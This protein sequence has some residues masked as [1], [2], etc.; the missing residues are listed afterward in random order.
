MRAGSRRAPRPRAGPAPAAPAAGAPLAAAALAGRFAA[1]PAAAFTAVHQ[2][3][4]ESAIGWG[5]PGTPPAAGAPEDAADASDA[6]G[7]AES[8]ESAPRATP[9][10]TLALPLAMLEPLRCLPAPPPARGLHPQ[11]LRLDAP[12]AA[13]RP[14]PRARASGAASCDSA[15]TQE[16]AVRPDGPADDAADEPSEVRV[17]RLRTHMSLSTSSQPDAGAPV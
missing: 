3:A 13:A 15:S 17:R 1:V 16:P 5:G 8:A 11:M 9:A 2:L 6:A 10:P 14:P 4:W 12:A 7:G